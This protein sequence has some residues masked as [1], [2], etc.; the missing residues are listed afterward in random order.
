V[1]GR[2][3]RFTIDDFTN[4]VR[5]AQFVNAPPGVTFRGDPGV[6]EDGTRGDYD[7]VGARVGF[8]LSLTRDGRT[9]LRGGGMFYDQHLLGEFNNGA[10]N[11]PPW[12]IR[13]SLVAPDGPFSDPYRGR[14]D[15]DLITPSTIG[16]RDAPF[17]RPVLVNTYGDR[18]VTPLT[19][20]WN[21]TFEREVVTGWLARAAYVGSSSKNGRAE[22]Q[23]NPA[24]YIP[25]NGP[26]GTPL[27]TTG[28]TD[29]RRLFAPQLGSITL[30]T[31]DRSSRYHSLQL[32]LNRRYAN[33]LTIT[34]NYTLSKSE[35]NFGDQLI[36]WFLPDDPALTDGP[37][38]QDRRH[39]F[40]GSW[41][42]DLPAL[43][44]TMRLVRGLLHGWQWTGIVQYQSG[45]PNTITSGRDNSL[46]G[47][48][49]DR[50]KFTGAS[51]DPPA[52]ADR[53]VWFNPAA[54][55][56]ND[57]GTFGDVGK[58]A[59][60]GPALYYWDM[61]LFKNLPVGGHVKLQFRAEFFN[62]FNQVNFDLP[63]R[64]VSGGG[65]GTI[66]AT[67][68]FAGDPRIIQFGLKMTF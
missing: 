68:P 50:A 48:G 44:T 16:S 12:S 56:V 1:A 49:N 19:Y 15:F 3:Q 42:W 66:T 39:R 9:S 21:L 41:V 57:I 30:F 63:N 59:F 24:R 11:A 60:T 33:G 14:S 54:F 46:D 6:P 58:G 62:V 38:D 13:L 55:A 52:G 64:N 7:N 53:R 29:S 17:P 4:G 20:N 45:A 8:A 34:G 40:V 32:T 35:G 31:Q 65:F 27:S 51:I 2:I 36:P 10:V 22:I 67:H 23:L 43:P 5:S 25:G 28:N 18:F 37:L 61:G 26:T 47:I